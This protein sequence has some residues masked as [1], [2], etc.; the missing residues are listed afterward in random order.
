MKPENNELLACPRVSGFLKEH[1]VGNSPSLRYGD[2]WSHY[3]IESLVELAVKLERELI[4]ATTPTT[5]KDFT[6]ICVKPPCR[7][8][9]IGYC[10]KCSTAPTTDAGIDEA[11]K[12]CR[13]SLGLRRTYTEEVEIIKQAILSYAAALT[14]ELEKAKEDLRQ[15]DEA[16]DWFCDW[17]NKGMARG[18][19]GY[20]HVDGICY[21]TK[22]CAEDKDASR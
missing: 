10:P 22:E 20:C 13:K 7:H 2:D 18:Q 11:A 8:N 1:G 9:T 15:A 19:E 3:D 5:E 16:H 21:C 17:C 14:I 6:I 4:A 12:A